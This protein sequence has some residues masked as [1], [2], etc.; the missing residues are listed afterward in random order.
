MWE[1]EPGH[2]ASDPAGMDG[3]DLGDDIVW[4]RFGAD[5]RLYATNPEYGLF[6]VAPGTSWRTNPNAMATIDR[7]NSLFTNVALTD[8]GDVWWE[9]MT[10]DP[11]A[12]RPTG[13]GK[14]G[15]R[16]RPLGRRP[17][18]TAGSAHPLHSARSSRPNMAIRPESRSTPSSSA[19][20]GRTRCH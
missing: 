17:T 12:H 6:G 20:V 18:R 13:A 1:D 3:G 11:P 2:V 15:R 7:G 5:G 4:M 16:R 9:G 19:G 14:A 8:D 10:K